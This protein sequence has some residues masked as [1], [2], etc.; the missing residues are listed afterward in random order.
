M[1]AHPYVRG[2]APRRVCNRRTLVL[3]LAVAAGCR[4][5][6]GSRTGDDGR[7]SAAPPPVTPHLIIMMRGMEAGSERTAWRSSSSGRSLRAETIVGVPSPIAIR[8]QSDLDVDTSGRPVDLRVSGTSYPWQRGAVGSPPAASPFPLA[9]QALLATEWKRRGRPGSLAGPARGG[10]SIEACGLERLPGV[11]IGREETA[12]ECFLVAGLTWGRTVIWLASD[13]RLAAAVVPTALA[14]LVA[15]PPGASA[16]YDSVLSAAARH[17]VER[18]LPRRGLET[19]PAVAIVGVR[20]VAG[21]ERPV[22]EDGVV[23][24]RD[25]RLAA[26]GPRGSTPVP[27]GVRTID[28]SGLT[29]VPGLWDMHA[30]LKQAEWLPAYAA[31]GITTVRDLGNEPAQL[32]AYRTALRRGDRLGPRILAAGFIDALPPSN[33]PYTG[34]ALQAN[35]PDAGRRLVRRYHALGYDQIKVWANVR[36]AVLRAIAAEAHALGLR[37]TGHVPAGIDAL[38]AVRFGMDEIAHMNALLAALG[39]A[40]PASPAGARFIDSLRRA[41]VVVDPTLVVT[42]YA[43]RS[44]SVPLRE[45]EPCAADVPPELVSLWDGLAAD[46]GDSAEGEAIV[47]K[48]LGAVRALHRAGVPIVAGTDQGIPACTLM[49]E[50]EL[51]VRAG[52]TPLEAIGAATSVPARVMGLLGEVGTVTAGSRADLLV[53]DGDPSRDIGVLADH[54]PLAVLKGGAVVAGSLPGGDNA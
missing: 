46:P 20:V 29:V 50:L 27:R 37:V 12:F 32:L 23:V 21:D 24:V 4:Q 17:G 13:G 48:A 1:T 42:R 22:L 6:S 31:A 16:A 30:H 41:H 19:A 54:E 51:Y 39:N 26:V 8:L 35:T 9:L 2:A 18:A 53:V 40:D 15:L 47:T 10:V 33:R 36:P 38:T 34:P 49:H 44:R 25:G 11:A 14:P 52:L 3:L 45:F 28:G 7:A 5:A 43:T